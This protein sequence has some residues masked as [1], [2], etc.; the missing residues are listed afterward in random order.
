MNLNTDADNHMIEKI[1]D[2]KLDRQI[3]R[4]IIQQE[5]EE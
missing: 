5:E 2:G 1:R 4:I 3:Q